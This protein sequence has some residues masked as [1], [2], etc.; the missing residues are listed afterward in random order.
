MGWGYS[1]Q[2]SQ[3]VYFKLIR[4]F[5]SQSRSLHRAWVEMA[6]RSVEMAAPLAALLAAALV[7]A[8]SHEPT[9][10]PILFEAAFQGRIIYLRT[11]VGIYL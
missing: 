1:V 10:E 3:G 2:Y 6:W 11:N 7:T 8:T 5:L 4:L 9:Q